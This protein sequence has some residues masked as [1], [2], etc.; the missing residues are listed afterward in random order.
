MICLLLARRRGSAGFFKGLSD[1]IILKILSHL[2]DG[3]I[4]EKPLSL[5]SVIFLLERNLLY[6]GLRNLFRAGGNSMPQLF[7]RVKL[8]IDSSTTPQAVKALAKRVLAAR[9]LE[10]LQG[11]LASV[12]MPQSENPSAFQREF[13]QLITLWKTRLLPAG[14]KRQVLSETGVGAGAGAGAGAGGEGEGEGVRTYNSI[15]STG[16]ASLQDCFFKEV[17]AYIA[18]QRAKT[19]WKPGRTNSAGGR[20]NA[21]N[22]RVWLEGARQYFA[23]YPD[24]T[25]DLNQVRQ[26]KV[27]INGS[28]QT[29]DEIVRTGAHLGRLSGTSTEMLLKA[30]Q[31]KRDCSPQTPTPVG[32]SAAAH[33]AWF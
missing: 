9:S 29:L 16:K 33:Q 10:D 5:E 31:A 11:L 24:R 1:F 4:R 23:S 12:D 13:Q 28:D 2:S 22:A 32:S 6:S 19:S 30:A 20:K 18:S 15:E 8:S 26:R 7:S 17:E 27:A 14:G 25:D 3:E 21:E